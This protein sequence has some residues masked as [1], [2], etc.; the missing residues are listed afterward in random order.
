[1]MGRREEGH[2]AR[3]ST[4]LLRAGMAF[5]SNGHCPPSPGPPS[6]HFSEA[7][8]APASPSPKKNPDLRPA[9]YFSPSILRRPMAEGKQ[10]QARGPRWPCWCWHWV[11]VR[12]GKSPPSLAHCGCFLYVSPFSP[13]LPSSLTSWGAPPSQQAPRFPLSSVSLAAASSFPLQPLVPSSHFLPSSLSNTY[14]T[15]ITACYVSMAMLGPGRGRVAD[16]G[17]F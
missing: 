15:V 2:L 9:S 12:V 5:P 14:C 3:D 16:T 7:T 4:S 1:M 17:M 10:R 8:E 11:G 6:P 13:S